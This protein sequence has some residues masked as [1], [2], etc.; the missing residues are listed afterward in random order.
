MSAT[1]S[2]SSAASYVD[3]TDDELSLRD[4]FAA[5][6]Q[7]DSSAFGEIYRRCEP[8]VRRQLAGRVPPS[9]IDDLVNETFLRAWRS[10]QQF[11]WQGTDPI[12]WV[13]VIARNLAA[14]YWSL[15]RN[16]RELASE[17]PAVYGPQVSHRGAEDVVIDLVEAERLR[18]AVRQLP[19]A[20]RQC[21]ELRFLGRALGT[22]DRRGHGPPGRRGALAAAAGPALAGR[23]RLRR[24]RRTGQ[25]TPAS[26]PRRA[27]LGRTAG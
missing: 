11:R 12:A 2:T 20:Q 7:G 10:L 19:P 4:I 15:A 17:D 5:A 18:A 24:T 26:S 21:L 27:G 1:A 22:R 13:L 8:R 3:L 25:L 23:T 16:R 9:Q 6:Q 14:D